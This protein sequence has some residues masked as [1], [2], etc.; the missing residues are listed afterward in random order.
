MSSKKPQHATVNKPFRPQRPK[1]KDP[2][3][4]A[5]FDIPQMWRDEQIRNRVRLSQQTSQA[6]MPWSHTREA[7]NTGTINDSTGNM[8]DIRMFME[9]KGGRTSKAMNGVLRAA[10]AAQ[11]L[12]ANELED[13]RMP[14]E[15]LHA[16]EDGEPPI[17]LDKNRPSRPPTRAKSDRSRRTKSS[18]LPLERTPAE[19]HVQNLSLTLPSASKSMSGRFGT[20]DV[21]AF[22][23]DRRAALPGLC[24]VF[25]NEELTVLAK[26]VKDLVQVS[27][28]HRFPLGHPFERQMVGA[29]RSPVETEEV[30]EEMLKC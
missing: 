13:Q 24:G 17:E 21:A 1:G 14:L 27:K 18:M 25:T 15:S 11:N 2:E 19:H 9:R 5:W 7:S 3:K 10:S 4:D 16:L 29:L 23:A 22:D 20:D 26:K 8:G 28:G 6:A 30:E 12:E